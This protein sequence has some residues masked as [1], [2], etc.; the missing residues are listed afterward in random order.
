MQAVRDE[1]KKG[2]AMSEKPKEGEA[3]SAVETGE[4]PVDP[5]SGVGR[6]GSAQPTEAELEQSAISP[7]H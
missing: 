3:G 6:K 7:R 5:N 2:M 4:H 1:D